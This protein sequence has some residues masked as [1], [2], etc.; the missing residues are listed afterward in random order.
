M[1]LSAL[2][3]DASGFLTSFFASRHKLSQSAALELRTC[4]KD[5][6]KVTPLLGGEAQVYFSRLRNL[7]EAVL[8]TLGVLR[9]AT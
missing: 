4:F 1:D 2:D 8:E 3:A 9:R 7:T 5:L 6:H